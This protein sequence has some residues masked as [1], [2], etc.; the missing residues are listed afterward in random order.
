MIYTLV[1]KSKDD[2]VDSVF[3][4]SSIT[5]LDESWSATVTSQTVEFG[6]DV[7][8][9][10]NIEAPTYSIDAILSNYSLFDTR[11]E[12]VWDGDTFNSQDSYDGELHIKARDTLIDIFKS[13]SIL[14]LIE[15][16]ENS[17][18]KSLE[19][20]MSDLAAGYYKEIPN[21]VITSLSIS[22][23]SNGFGAFLVSLKVQKI[24]VAK[25]SVIELSKD[26]INPLLRPVLIKP[27]VAA[28]QS[29]TLDGEVIDETV[30]EQD[31][32][33]KPST[34]G[35]PREGMEWFEVYDQKTGQ[36]KPIKDEIAAQKEMNEHMAITNQYCTLFRRSDG[37]YKRCRMT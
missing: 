11:K 31:G 5:S 35:E 29:K 37:Y 4:F 18:S 34:N 21:C 8:D 10:I 33:I 12:I 7:T 2:V 23:P 19:F 14:T 27:T 28:S 9:N 17:N 36:L 26:E 25:V 22:N 3:S 16:S 24:N 1:K 6:F 30:A 20:K 15:S 32:D 13:R